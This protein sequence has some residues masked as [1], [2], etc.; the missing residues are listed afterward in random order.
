[1][2]NE[3][4]KKQPGKFEVVG[5]IGKPFFIGW[6]TRPED[7]PLRDAISAEIRKLRDNGQLAELQKKWFGASM[8]IPDAGY[9]PEGAK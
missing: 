9:L 7:T 6:V 5:T 3:A 8:T 2:I 4:M 1:V